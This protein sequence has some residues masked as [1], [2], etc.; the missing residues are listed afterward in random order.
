MK[1]VGKGAAAVAAVPAAGIAAQLMVF[2]MFL[3]WLKAMMAAAVAMAANLMSMIMAAI[4]TAVNAVVSAVMAVGAGVAAVVGGAISAT[5]GAV[6]AVGMSLLAL[7]G[8]GAGAVAASGN[9]TAQRDGLPPD[10]RPEAEA[11]IREIDDSVEDDVD[12]RMEES[13]EQVYA[14]LAGLGMPDENIAGILGNF[15]KESR[16]DPTMVEFIGGESFGIDS[17]KRDAEEKNFKLSELED[18]DYPEGSGVDLLGIGLGQWSN[19]RNTKLRDYAEETGGEWH[20][21]ET[22]MQFLISGDDAQYVSIVDQ[23][24]N[25]SSPSVSAS[26]ETWLKKWEI[27]GDMGSAEISEREGYASMWFSKMG[28]WEADVEL[29]DSIIEQ[30]EANL[31]EANQNRRDA[32][33]AQCRTVAEGASGSVFS[34][35]DLIEC[36]NLQIHEVTCELHER[37]HEEFGG[38]YDHAGGFREFSGGAMDNHNTG[39]AIDYML[40]PPGIENDADRIPTPEMKRTGDVVAAWLVENHEE[41]Q[42]KGVVWNHRIWSLRQNQGMSGAWD[43]VSVH[44]KDRGSNTQNH[45]DHVHVSAGPSP[46]M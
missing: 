37:L 20:E 43:D 7:V 23:F 14:F 24:I 45:I 44:A 33:I 6:A 13:A 12:K 10:C 39:E 41:Y 25:D 9:T 11:T 42:I 2:A 21:F 30:A 22:Q 38:F 18:N 27:A 19:T 29:A 40:I 31:G 36:G 8:I 1:G 35:G 16:M 4:M 32:V 17:T 34:A 3:S 5:T 26:T 15:H 46:F 28:D